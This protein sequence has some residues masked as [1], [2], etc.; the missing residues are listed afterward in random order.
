MCFLVRPLRG[1][2]GLT[3][4]SAGQG[5]GGRLRRAVRISAAGLLAAA[6]VAT[7]ASNC[8]VDSFELSESATPNGGHTAT[9]SGAGGSGG[10]SPSCAHAVWPSAPAMSDPGGEDVE[11]VLA[12][13]SVDFGE[14]DLSAGPTVGYDLDGRCSCQGEQASCQNAAS[15]G[16]EQC[17]GPAGRD[18]VTAMIFKQLGTFDPAKRTSEAWTAEIESGDWSLLF[19]V[20]DYNGKPN[21]DQVQVALYP[22]PGLDEDGCSNDPTPKWDG[23]DQWPVSVTALDGGG[24]GGQGGAGGCGGSTSSEALDSPKYVDDNAYVT[25]SVLV[26]NLPELALVLDRGYSHTILK[27]TAGFVSGRLEAD[28]E[29]GGW[30]LRDGLLVGRWKVS[31]FFEMLSN[32]DYKSEPLCTDTAIYQAIKA[33]ACPKL[34]LT[35]VLAGPTKPCDALS[36]GI[37]IEAQSAKLG[38]I[39]Q[40]APPQSACPPATNPVGDSCD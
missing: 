13:R 1:H 7:A 35:S 24:A 4:L 30:S 27:L 19:R 6:L 23:N 38:T 40:S 21:D 14:D 22:S 36:F 26:A 2:F 5:V 17:D 34:D 10:K 37:A 11:F 20:R 16:E 3:R 12:M 28:S 9:S 8:V 15:V 31:D 33:T 25:S 39:D 18:N 32:L 29:V